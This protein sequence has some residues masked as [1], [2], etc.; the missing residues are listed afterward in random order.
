M[1][2]LSGQESDQVAYND[3]SQKTSDRVLD[4]AQMGSDKG[5]LTGLSMSVQGCCERQF[6][7]RRTHSW[8]PVWEPSVS[9][10]N[11]V[12]VCDPGEASKPTAHHSQGLWQRPN[13]P[14]EL[15]SFTSPPPGVM[16]SGQQ[17]PSSA[18]KLSERK[19]RLSKRSLN[20]HHH[21]HGL[22]LP[23]F[24]RLPN[25]G[26]VSNA[27]GS[28]V[29]SRSH[30][31]QVTRKRRIASIFQ[32]YYPEGHWGFVV[33]VCG[34]LVQILT[35]GTQLSFGYFALTIRRRWRMHHASSDE[36]LTA[37]NPPSH[38]NWEIGA[39]SMA[40]SL[41]ASP[42]TIA[43]CRRKSTRL[44]AVL[45][46]L[47]C[48][49]A[50]LFTSFANQF[51]QVFFSYGILYGLGVGMSRDSAQ[52]MIGQYFKRRR[53]WVEMVFSAGTGLGLALM[54]MCLHF[55]LRN[56]GW[57]FGLQLMSSS[58]LLVVVL[59]TFYRSA[60]LYHPQRRAILHLKSQR[61]KIK[62]KDK[63]KNKAQDDKP[64]YFDFNTLKSRTIQLL[65]ASVFV[66]SLGIYSPLFYVM[67]P[68]DRN[69]PPSSS[70]ES[71]AWLYV[72]LGLAW[73]LGCLTFGGIVVTKSRD[74][75]IAR[76]YLCQ[77]SLL[78]CGISI[79]TFGTIQGYHGLVLFVWIYGA[80]LGGY[81]HALKMFVYEK[82]RS[83]NFA[84]SWS[85]VQFFQGLGALIGIP[86]TGLLCTSIGL[87]H[88]MLFSALAVFVSA[89]LIMS[90]ITVHRRNLR[91]KHQRHRQH[92]Q[93]QASL[94]NGSLTPMSLGIIPE[95]LS[96]H[97]ATSKDMMEPGLSHAWAKLAASSGHHPVLMEHLL[98]SLSD[99]VHFDGLSSRSL[100]LDQ[101][102]LHSS[103][104]ALV[105]DEE[106]IFSEEGIADMELPDHLLL[107]DIEYL[108]NITS[109]NK[110]ENCLMLSE[111]EQN[112]IKETESPAIGDPGRK[113]SR[114]MSIFKRNRSDFFS[115]KR[116]MGS[117]L[118]STG[119]ELGC[120]EPGLS[121]TRHVPLSGSP[122]KRTIRIIEEAVF[123]I[124][125]GK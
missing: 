93:N 83:R 61:R 33:L 113:G 2:S 88:G 31:S 107:D 4:P 101:I 79:S 17:Y 111:Y 44:T 16:V 87:R 106:S 58:M 51:H 38:L 73:S 63:E 54:T 77:A 19:I 10:S 3:V 74:C 118:P 110:V 64:P 67:R 71:M 68:W 26:Q 112:L 82:V 85:F 1:G 18:S 89:V 76:Q 117:H 22:K 116:K 122:L 30:N 100:N 32:H 15:I 70:S 13:G 124:S 104:E 123:M 99:P 24:L 57:R 91:Q 75:A 84:S 92:K 6:S 103:A 97:S 50:F 42:M 109:C 55:S 5:L 98:S 12:I 125:R 34:L 39:L 45:G 52:L 36:G 115:P 81:H 108:D 95:I 47:I 29:G 60:S 37:P 65:L 43:V 69:L 94:R 25:P 20:P 9:D 21:V 114:K 62:S 66:S 7:R 80:F 78:L 96:H 8:P 105:Q 53:E 86:G 23:E 72:Y 41:L 59:G 49:F 56:L 14:Q 120:L 11:G 90:L 102:L 35:H 28:Q 27:D 46:G 119:D 121:P 40:V 48:T